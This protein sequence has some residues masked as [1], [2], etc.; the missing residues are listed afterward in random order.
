MPHDSH[1]SNQPRNKSTLAAG[2]STDDRGH[3]TVDR[4]HQPID[5][6]IPA[7]DRQRSQTTV[8]LKRTTVEAQEAA[9]QIPIALQHHKRLQSR[10]PHLTGHHKIHWL[11]LDRAIQTASTKTQ[12]P[13]TLSKLEQ[14][15]FSHSARSATRPRYSPTTTRMRTQ[16]Q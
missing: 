12:K 2:A 5:R 4:Q 1:C 3:W 8:G 6:Q 9:T 10:L 11:K 15:Q 14:P 7:H 13:Q 16:I